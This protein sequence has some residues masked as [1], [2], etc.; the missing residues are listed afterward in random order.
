MGWSARFIIH[1]TIYPFIYF[2]CYRRF[3]GPTKTQRASCYFR[4]FSIFSCRGMVNAALKLSWFNPNLHTHT[5][6]HF[7][8]FTYFKQKIPGCIEGSCSR[9]VIVDDINVRPLCGFAV[10]R[11]N[12][13]R[14]SLFVAC[15]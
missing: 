5:G 4:V 3:F 13:D 6:T 12:A 10:M 1:P 14:H 8:L 7:T 9:C 2:C 11:D 15:N